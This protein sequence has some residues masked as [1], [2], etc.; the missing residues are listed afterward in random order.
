VQ[1]YL[2]SVPSTYTP[3]TSTKFRLD[4][5]CHGR[6]ETLTEMAFIYGKPPAATD[7][8]TVGLYGRYC[9]ANKFA[10][11]IDLLEAMDAVKGLYPIDENR[12]VVIGFSMG[13]AA[14]WQFAVHYTDL[15]CAA[16]PGAGFAETKEFLKV[17]QKEEV[18]PPWWEQTLWHWYDCTDYA[19][20]L[21]NLP[22][23]AYAGEIDPQKQA[24]DMMEK[25]MAAEGL[26]LER[27]IG[28]GTKHA[29]EPKTKIEL[30]KRL[31]AYAAKG[32]NPVPQKIRFTTWTLRYPH[33]FWVHV[34]GLDKHWERARV[35]AEIAGQTAVKAKTQNV[36][37]LTLS[38]PAGECPF[39][40]GSK[41]SVTI[42][43]TTLEGP[44]VAQDKSWVAK[45]AKSGTAWITA[46]AAEGRLRKRPGLQG[47]IDDAFLDRFIMVLPTGKPLSEKT[48]KWAEAESK[49]AI[50]H[51]RKQFRGEAI[52]KKD[53]EVTDGDIEKSNLVLWGDPASNRVLAKMAA[54]LPVKW[55]GDA[56]L[57]GAKTFPSSHHIPAL[58]YP[59]PLNPGRYV[60]LNSGFTY[61]EYDYLNNARQTPKLPDFAILDVETPAS[62]RSPAGVAYAGFFDEG[63]Q[64]LPDDRQPKP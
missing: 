10:G 37:M 33:M 63:W 16:S 19:V 4:L 26:T 28:P 23:V 9:N 14:C 62:S 46:P 15:F 34:E 31:D 47:P 49:H 59:N 1:P 20:N 27:L 24:S 7:H 58:I 3:G 29:Y 17:F 45:F 57:I 38:F 21:F 5:S 2:L 30:D 56:V 60:V 48:G 54:K 51:W 41:P 43:A 11:E 22:T 64:V 40:A 8:F 35:D 39:A 12:V 36:S 42:D 6:S 18:A 25:A 44:A 61:R 53:T 55:G 50:D 13:G 52:V 32:R